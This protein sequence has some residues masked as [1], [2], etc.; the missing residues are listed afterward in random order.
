ML[1]KA[2]SMTDTLEP[3]KRPYQL[4]L[5]TPSMASRVHSPLGCCLF[6]IIRSAFSI[7]RL[8]GYSASISAMQ[9]HAVLTTWDRS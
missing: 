3:L 2:V 5:K 6:A 9:T 8:S 4:L 7:G 1:F